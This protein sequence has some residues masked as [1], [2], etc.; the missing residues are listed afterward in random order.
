MS[1]LASILGSGKVIEKGLDLI[2]DA[3]TTEEEARDSKLNAKERL[4]KSY[5]P[6]KVAQRYLAVLFA[7]NFLASFW[8]AVL[9]WA[10]DKDMKGFIDIMEV[11]NVGWIMTTIVLFYFGGGLAESIRRKDN[12]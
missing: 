11:F 4:L 10:F 5:A 12:G 9:L 1:V 3:W 8:V 6:F 7:V 2:D